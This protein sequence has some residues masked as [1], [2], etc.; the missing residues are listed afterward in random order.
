MVSQAV[1][2]LSL[3]ALA[4]LVEPEA[5][6]TVALGMTLVA[7][8]GVVMEAGG[9]GS[10]IAGRDITPAGIWHTLRLNVGIGA[11]LAVLMAA[12]AVP[13]VDVF[14]PGGD[15]AV[16]RVLAF[17]LLLNALGIVPL[18]LLQKALRFR[19]I[20]TRNIA[21]SLVGG[22]GGVVAGLLGAGVWSLV[23][24]QLASAFLLTA[25][26][27]LAARGLVPRP[28]RGTTKTTRPPDARWFMLL[29]AATL[30]AM[31]GDNLLVGSQTDARQLGLYTLA[32]TLGFA[33]LTQVSWVVGRV[34]FPAA[35]ASDPAAVGSRTVKAT[36]ATAMLLLPVLPPALVLSPVLMP[37]VLGDRWE[38]SVPVFQLLLVAG[39]L[40][41]LTNIVGESLSG[42]GQ[43]AWRSKVTAAA[44]ALLI[45]GVLFG[46]ANN[47]IEGAALA[48]LLG[49]IPLAV[50][51]A[52]GGL[53]RAGSSWG[54][55]WEQMR[56]L[57]A[58]CAAQ[59]AVVLVA[60]LALEGQGEWVAAGSAAAAGIAVIAVGLLATHG[61]NLRGVLA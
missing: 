40:H 15:P 41:A 13:I 14:A 4:V 21:A 51:M 57:V 30:A 46:A 2:W 50:A 59:T 28:E 31:S 61:R 60:W 27:W 38:G 54:A 17:G 18:A 58:L 5:F 24:R 45:A 16:I 44:T 37:A 23:I 33:P 55:L 35:A 9:T 39:V 56:G 8:M 19:Q 47:G 6:G 25:G 36:R 22:S 49:V 1:W 11:V 53:R 32:F 42:V 10:L 20:A 43:I 12:L 52:T 26:A 34:L 29:A 48:H 7:T 3:I